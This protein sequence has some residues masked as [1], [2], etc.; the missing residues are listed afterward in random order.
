MAM[1][2]IMTFDYSAIKPARAEQT[3]R[4]RRRTAGSAWGGGGRQGRGR[5][6]NMRALL[7]V[8]LFDFARQLLLSSL[9]LLPSVAASAS[10]ATGH[11]RMSCLG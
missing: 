5:G 9:L 11:D 8:H 4:L 6:R 3:E 1:L 2:D 7:L 10:A